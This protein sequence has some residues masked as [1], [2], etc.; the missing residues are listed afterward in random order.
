MAKLKIRIFP[1]PALRVKADKVRSMGPTEKGLLTDMARAMYLNHGVGLAATQIG[2]AKSLV[3]IDV[4]DGL[5]KLANPVITKREGTQISEEGC[6]SV[7]GECIKIKRAV[8]VFVNFLNEGGKPAHIKAEGLLAKAVQHE[9]D[10]LPGKL[11]IDYLNPIKKLLR[12]T[13]SCRRM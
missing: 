12:R 6:L 11:I 1:D 8:T 4:G 5:I 13:K 9:L 7:P 3:V 10:H 2:V